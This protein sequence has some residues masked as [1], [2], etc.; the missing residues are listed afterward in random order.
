MYLEQHVKQDIAFAFGVSA[1]AVQCRILATTVAC[2]RRELDMFGP[3]TD[4]GEEANQKSHCRVYLWRSWMGWF[5]QQLGWRSSSF[6]FCAPTVNETISMMMRNLL[7]P[8]MI[9]GRVRNGGLCRQSLHPLFCCARN[10]LLDA[11]A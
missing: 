9:S 10:Q 5:M 11:E 8:S 3:A 6:N 2:H 7:L 4:T 1:R